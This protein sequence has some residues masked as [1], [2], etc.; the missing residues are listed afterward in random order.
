MTMS[1]CWADAKVSTNGE[2]GDY[3]TDFYQCRVRAWTGAAARESLRRDRPGG[4][5]VAA[6]TEIISSTLV[7]TNLMM[8][9]ASRQ[10]QRGL[11]HQLLPSH[12]CPSYASDGRALLS[13]DDANYFDTDHK[14]RERL[15]RSK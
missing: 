15:Q 14:T 1:N 8:Y 5:T 6:T 2:A 11:R 9:V 10:C 13:H 12:A 4:L 7:L 3:F